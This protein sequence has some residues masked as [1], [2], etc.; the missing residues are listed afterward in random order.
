MTAAAI[1]ISRY[2][3]EWEML[4]RLAEYLRAGRAD[5]YDKLIAAGHLTAEQAFMDRHARAEIAAEW[6]AIATDTPYTG[7][8]Y[9]PT[10]WRIAALEAALSGA[11]DR[12]R[13][14]SEADIAHADHVDLRDAIACLLSYERSPTGNPLW[15]QAHRRAQLTP[16]QEA[17]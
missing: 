6:Q 10:Y 13:R 14:I 11:E 15:W 4:A 17:A 9:A 16:D 8:R 12:L 7:E 5:S 1:S 3:G 2:N